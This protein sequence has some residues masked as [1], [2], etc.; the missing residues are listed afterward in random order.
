MP[1][2][3]CAANV[4]ET[5]V[6]VAITRKT[7]PSQTEKYSQGQVSPATVQGAQLG[8]ATK[9]AVGMP[10]S[11]AQWAACR[12]VA[13]AILAASQRGFPAAG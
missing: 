4:W 6:V 1:T 8:T 2:L 11:L 5:H 7:L 12:Y 10:P 9:L 13:A 3:V